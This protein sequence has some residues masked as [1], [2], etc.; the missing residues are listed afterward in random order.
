MGEANNPAAARPADDVYCW[1]EQDSSVMLKAVTQFGDPVELTAADAR[2]IAAALLTL[3]GRLEPG[4]EG[5]AE[6]TAA[7]DGGGE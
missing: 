7:A 5:P 6:P 4:A 3:A 1:L 2:S